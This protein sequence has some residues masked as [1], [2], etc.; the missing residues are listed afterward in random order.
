MSTGAVTITANNKPCPCGSGFKY[1]HCCKNKEVRP[2]SQTSLKSEWINLGYPISIH[3]S[4]L[5]SNLP[6]NLAIIAFN[7]LIMACLPY[8]YQTI[9]FLHSEKYSKQAFAILSVKSVEPSRVPDV[10]FMVHGLIQPVN[11]E[12]KTTMFDLLLPRYHIGRPNGVVLAE[13]ISYDVYLLSI[14]NA[15]KCLSELE[16]DI[17][18]NMDEQMTNEIEQYHLSLSEKS[19]ATYES[20]TVYREH[21]RNLFD[22]FKAAVVQHEYCLQLTDSKHQLSKQLDR[23]KQLQDAVDVMKTSMLEAQEK[24][25]KTSF[26]FI[27]ETNQQVITT[28][29]PNLLPSVIRSIGRAEADREIKKEDQNA[30]DDVIFN[31]VRAVEAQLRE[32]LCEQLGPIEPSLGEMVKMIDNKKLFTKLPSQCIGKLYEL[33]NYRNPVSHGKE[34]HWKAVDRIRQ[35]LF[36][37]KLLYHLNS[38][39]S[40]KL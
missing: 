16:I 11:A 28:K 39:A 32:N 18:F 9:G 29:Y 4:I 12:I 17:A 13:E 3:R 37:E 40:L 6:R 38:W 25:E 7:R 35:I 36:D 21:L 27:Y 23:N 24:I 31:Y 15:Y 22:A 34:S 14:E 26:S 10:L 20:L 33:A 2:V 30:A 1:K 8:N 19:L 5:P